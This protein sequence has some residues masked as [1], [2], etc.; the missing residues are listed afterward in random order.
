MRIREL[1]PLPGGSLPWLHW[2][3]S[4][5]PAPD[6]WLPPQR[7]HSFS[8][9][10]RDH[11]Q[12]YFSNGRDSQVSLLP[13]FSSDTI[14]KPSCCLLS[15]GRNTD[16]TP[17]PYFSRGYAVWTFWLRQHSERSSALFLQRQETQLPWPSFSSGPDTL[18]IISQP[19]LLTAPPHPEAHL[20]RKG[21]SSFSISLSPRASPSCLLLL[22]WPPRWPPPSLTK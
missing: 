7:V 10:Q 12:P 20:L 8:K 1:L 2:G 5:S 17:P 14:R 19:F 6:R 3:L 13:Y 9:G 11:P 4:V 15:Y 22:L 18:V 16:T 21:H